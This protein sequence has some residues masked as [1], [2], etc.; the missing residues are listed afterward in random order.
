MEESFK[1]NKYLFVHI[2][3]CAGSS[4]TYSLSGKH[5]AKYDEK[6]KL[7]VQHATAKELKDFYF[8]EKEW[9]SLF[10]FAIVRNPFER[11]VSSYNFLCTAMKMPKNKPTFKDFV[12]KKNVFGKLLDPNAPDKRGNFYHH[13]RPMVKYLF[14]EG[15]LLVDFI[16]RFENLEDD[17]KYISKRIKKDKKLIHSN[18]ISHPHYIDYYDEQLKNKVAEEYKEDLEVFGYKFGE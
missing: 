15:E 16:G 17:W 10:K 11:V 4:I 5:F 2:P 1:K 6:R 8:N 12:Y 9:K 3:K 7:Y 14:E 13:S 18:K